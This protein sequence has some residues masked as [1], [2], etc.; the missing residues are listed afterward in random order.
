VPDFDN[1]LRGAL[2]RNDKNGNEKAPDYRGSCEIDHV[3]YWVSSWIRTSKA[4]QKFMSLSFER[5]KPA[6][7]RAASPRQAE[8]FSDDI[9]F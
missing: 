3:Q 9:P 1:N 8:E 4:G 5:K 7:Q 6:Q 2:F